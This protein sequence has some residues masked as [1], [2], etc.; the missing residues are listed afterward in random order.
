MRIKL[1]FIFFLIFTVKSFAQIK[2]PGE[3]LG[4]RL[5][6]HFTPHYKIVNYFQQMATAEPQMMKLE[7]YGQT[8]EGRQ[9]LLAIV[10]S[11]ENMA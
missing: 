2:S 7:T 10:S 11:P 9:L 4:Y 1:F 5:G 8:N 6:S 3:F